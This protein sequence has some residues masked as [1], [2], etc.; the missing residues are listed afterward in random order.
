MTLQDCE[1]NN[2]TVEGWQAVAS[3]LVALQ[4]HKP[5]GPA[6]LITFKTLPPGGPRS[7]PGRKE[8]TPRGRYHRSRGEDPKYM[9]P[10]STA[11]RVL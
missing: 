2:Q 1:G 8:L 5:L 3:A 4:L 9:E 10:D 11:Y 7:G 6:P